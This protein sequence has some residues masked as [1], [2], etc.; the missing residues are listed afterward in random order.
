MCKIFLDT[1]IFF[2]CAKLAVSYT[3]VLVFEQNLENHCE[4]SLKKNNLLTEVA[5]K[6]Y[7]IE[8]LN[9]GEI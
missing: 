3:E 5:Q 4:D 9:I 6:I 8:I 1:D 2:L 7:I